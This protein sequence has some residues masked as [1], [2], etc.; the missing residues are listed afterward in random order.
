MQI[1]YEMISNA[2]VRQRTVLL[3]QKEKIKTKLY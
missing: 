1:G 2:H 3:Q